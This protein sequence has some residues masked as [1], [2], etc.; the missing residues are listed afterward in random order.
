MKKSIYALLCVLGIAGNVCGMEVETQAQV[1]NM[2]VE[3]TDVHL[4]TRDELKQNKKQ[5]RLSNFNYR[6][7]RNHEFAYGIL[8]IDTMRVDADPESSNSNFKKY[9]LS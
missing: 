3:D 5:E 1:S 7:Q 6:C 4:M 9:S 8:M 2:Y